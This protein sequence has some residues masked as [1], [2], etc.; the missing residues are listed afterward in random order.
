M[1]KDFHHHLVYAL[2]KVVGFNKK[3]EGS[4]E[5]EA[6]IIAYASQYV[7]DNRGKI[8]LGLT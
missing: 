1:E 8:H 6:E 4:D 7:D 5:T 3:I 2:A